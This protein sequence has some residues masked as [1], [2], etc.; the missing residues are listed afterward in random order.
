MRTLY[1]RI[2]FFKCIITVIILL[3]YY[4]FYAQNISSGSNCQEI[5]PAL[6]Y[7]RSLFPSDNF[8]ISKINALTEQV[9]EYVTPLLVDIDGDCIPELIAGG[10]NIFNQIRLTRNILVFS[11][12]T[13]NLINEIVTP[14]YAWSSPNSFAVADVD[15]DGRVEI[16]IAA[17]STGL[18]SQA[19]RGRLV[20]IDLQSGITKW[21]SDRT[22]GDHVSYRY[23]GTPGLADFN[24]DGIAEVYIFDEI[25]NATNGIKLCS[26]VSFGKGVIYENIQYGSVGNSIAAQLDEDPNDLE[27]AAGFSV[28]KVSITN[29]NGL[30]GNFMTAYSIA[31][32]NRF[33]DGFT[34]VSDINK[35]GRLDVVVTCRGLRDGIVYVYQV[36]QGSTQLIASATLPTNNLSTGPP[37]IGDIDGTGRQFICFTRPY[38]LLSYYYDGTTVLKLFWR[39]T[40]NDE[41]GQTG[42]TMFDFNQDGIQE[43]VYRDETTLRIING[44]I[45]PPSN[46]TTFNCQSR[47]GN[48]YPIVGDVDNTGSAKICVVCGSNSGTT[49]AGLLNIF[50]HQ[51]GASPWAPARNVWNQYAYHVL[52]INDDLTIP[53]RMSNNAT[54][55]NGRLNNFY[56]QSSLLDDE[57]KFFQKVASLTG[58]NVCVTFDQ[59]KMTF[60]VNF[61]LQNLPEASANTPL[62]IPISLY[63]GT[64]S[65]PGKKLQTIYTTTALNAGATVNTYQFIIQDF[66][67]KD[68]FIVINTDK[69]LWTNSIEEENFLIGECN[70]SDNILPIDDFP[71]VI[72]LQQ[73]VCKGDNFSY[74]GNTFANEGT[75]IIQQKN[76]LGCDTAIHQLILEN[77][78]I[79]DAVVFMESCDSLVW[80]DL[81]LTSSGNYRYV[82]TSQYGCDSIIN[83]VFT[84]NTAS[85]NQVTISGCDSVSI[86]G[87][88]IYNSGSFTNTTKNQQGCDSTD[89][90]SVIILPSITNTLEVAQCEA[91]RFDDKWLIE[92]DLYTFKYKRSNGCD[93]II[94]INYERLSDSIVL[95]RSAC[96]SLYWQ[97]TNNVYYQSGAYLNNFTNQFFC[98]STQVLNLEIFPSYSI[99]EE[100][101]HCGPFD[102]RHLEEAVTSTGIWTKK[103][104]TSFGCDS[105]YVL[106]A[107][108][109]PNYRTIE[110]V[111]TINQYTWPV[112]GLSYHSSGIYTSSFVTNE[113][114]DSLRILD[115]KLQYVPQLY[116]P[117]VIGS[118]SDNSIFRIFGNEAVEKIIEFQVY[119]RWGNQVFQAQELDTNSL[120][121]N[122]T[123]NGRQLQQGVYLWIVRYV[124][125]DKTLQTLT[126]DITILK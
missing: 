39:L 33:R 84:R 16:I 38:S 123:M 64:P 8:S 81:I 67:I 22:F 76:S 23:G 118:N 18:N 30:Q 56:V 89:I 11:T 126:G 49:R 35:D 15:N 92:S 104:K 68:A 87:N 25:F 26:G 100:I 109:Y 66:S 2:I 4:N 97:Q 79:A 106:N 101:G 114:C 63:E 124:L 62:G 37:M 122:G 46:L 73:K 29:T 21:I 105:I 7:K 80:F 93:S 61:D 120:E 119:D 57:G 17:A 45:N 65:M 72:T 58:N 12:T 121:W 50:G 107:S 99:F 34:S 59:T 102:W 55:R 88:K 60:I 42:L 77:W 5:D 112:N 20:C 53:R 52:N 96:D 31:V 115:L 51:S 54:Y 117:N 111:D 32:N 44:S 86:E 78:E 116:Y 113:G 75:Y 74:L 48:E 13:G 85:V 108:I 41:S 3:F 27:L 28:Y 91:Y 1:T 43:I 94:I 83:M 103:Y 71:K 40:T 6:C 95:Y 47:T 90:Y 69:Q 19:T 9:A 110:Y 24:A 70:Y 125:Y 98:D 82:L 36:N 10:T 14:Y